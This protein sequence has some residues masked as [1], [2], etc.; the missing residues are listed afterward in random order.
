MNVEIERQVAAEVSTWVPSVAELSLWV[1]QVAEAKQ[2]PLWLTIRMVGAAESQQLNATYR[3]QDKPTN[4]L[5]FNF[6]P[7]PGFTPTDPYLGDLVI[8]AEVL[9][10]EAEAQLKIPTHHWAHIVIHGTLHLLG[11]DHEEPQAAAAMEE[12]ETALLAQLNIN[13]PYET[14]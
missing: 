5:S 13:N 8:C 2:R 10:A 6:E 1:S 3:G 4:I 14:V 11:Y 12:Q 9:A 7:P